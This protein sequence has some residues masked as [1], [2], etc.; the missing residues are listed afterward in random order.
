MQYRLLDSIAGGFAQPTARGIPLNGDVI[1]A[2][3]AGRQSSPD[4]SAYCGESIGWDI[5][6][7]RARAL[8]L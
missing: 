5:T 1:A 2:T 4:R 7:M 3:E 8:T 6:R